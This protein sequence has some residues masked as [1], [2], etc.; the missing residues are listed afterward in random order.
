MVHSLG[1]KPGDTLADVVFAICFA[2]FHKKV[3]LALVQAI[4][5]VIIEVA[6][7][8]IPDAHILS[9]S[10]PG[11]TPGCCAVPTH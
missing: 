8:A 3:V 1:V 7:P 2:K 10:V 5:S 11:V 9:D 4:L 6:P